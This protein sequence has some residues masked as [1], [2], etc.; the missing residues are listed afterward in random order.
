MRH[1]ARVNSPT[2]PPRIVIIGGGVGGVTAARS[3]RRAGADVT[4]LE[5]SP[6]L[7]GLVMSLEVAGTP[8]E[9]FYHHIFPQEHAI[10]GLIE[11]LGL[12]PKLAWLQSSTGVLT[13]GKVWPFT[14]PQDLLRF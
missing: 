6:N 8:I 3:L 7:G 2:A 5:A 4:V 11:D 10:R 14:T 12:T 13:G 1:D 9:A